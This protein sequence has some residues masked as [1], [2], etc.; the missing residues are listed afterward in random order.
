[1]S[2]STTWPLLTAKCLF[3]PILGRFWGFDPINVV[4]YCR[5]LQ[6]AHPCPKH[7]FW[8]IDRADR[9]RNTT[10]ARADESKKERKESQKFDKSHI[11]SDHP[12]CATPTK[13]VMWGGVSDIVN[14]AK[15]HQK[16]VKGFWLPEGSKSAIFLRLALWLI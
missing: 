10:W 13:V 15:F 1:M 2:S 3:P 4:E 6:K 8:R 5:D 12:R 11:C 9:S 7:A 14:H 16:L